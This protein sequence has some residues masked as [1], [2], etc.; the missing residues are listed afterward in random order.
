MSEKF[1]HDLSRQSTAA[2]G[3]PIMNC[4][5]PGCNV[6]WWPTRKRPTS[7]CPG[8]MLLTISLFVLN[9]VRERAEEMEGQHGCEASAAREYE[10]G[11]FEVVTEQMW[12]ALGLPSMTEQESARAL[13]GR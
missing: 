4:V 9:Q 5:N 7:I 3:T 8:A 2:N 1:P 6:V 10:R 11:R 13:A 12:Q